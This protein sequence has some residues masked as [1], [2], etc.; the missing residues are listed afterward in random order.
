MG[1]DLELIDF[2]KF[3]WARRQ[4]IFF[5]TF[6]T[7]VAAGIF[8]FFIPPTYEATTQIRMGRVW[9]E[10]LENPY[11]TSIL[12]NSDTFLEKIIKELNL[13][14]SLNHMRKGKIIETH[15][16]EGGKLREEVS[17]ANFSPNSRKRSS[18]GGKLGKCCW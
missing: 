5:G 12:I 14:I 13:P 10:E 2:F 9:G 6:L 17:F 18:N 3:F 4:L 16:L 7:A 11:L 1:K 8:S 15:V